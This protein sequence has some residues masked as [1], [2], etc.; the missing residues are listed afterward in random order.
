LITPK[1]RP[2]LLTWVTS[3]YSKDG[4]ACVDVAT[5]PDGGRAVRD[6]KDPE[7]PARRFTASAWHAL[8]S[9]ARDGEFGG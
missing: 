9:G 4:S 1:P 7:S 6:G 2:E 8:I 5:L 3:T